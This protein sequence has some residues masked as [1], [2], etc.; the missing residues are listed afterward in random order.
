MNVGLLLPELD[1]GATRTRVN[2]FLTHDFERL[3]MM[4]GRNL[5][6]LRSPQLSLAP[7]HSNGANG[8]EINIVQGL[9]AE[10][11]VR[12]VHHTIYHLPETYQLI[13][14]DRYIYQMRDWQIEKAL[15]YGRTRYNELKRRS[16]LFFADGF[17][18][19]Q[20]R[21]ECNPVI[22]LHVYQDSEQ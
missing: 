21:L 14:K 3:L 19:W 1:Y 10:A 15:C 2:E 18:Y 6:D 12:A 8:I 9:D 22:D 5:T 11:T 16:Q 7:G 4:S 17:D 20:K 13:M